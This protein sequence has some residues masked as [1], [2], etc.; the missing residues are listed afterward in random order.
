MYHL[1]SVWPLCGLGGYGGSRVPLV[2]A[3]RYR[4]SLDDRQVGEA[5][6]ASTTFEAGDKATICSLFSRIDCIMT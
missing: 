2:L 5:R 1:D 3:G 4:C 6:S